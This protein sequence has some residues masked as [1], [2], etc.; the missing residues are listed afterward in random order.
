MPHLFSDDLYAEVNYSQLYKQYVRNKV[1]IHKVLL[2]KQKNRF[3]DREL[4]KHIEK[5]DG[6]PA[7]RSF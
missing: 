4:K 6:T 7:P 2:Q 3:T 5:S 1:E